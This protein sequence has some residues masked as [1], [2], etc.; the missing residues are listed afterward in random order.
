M[1]K[2][3]K[4]RPKNKH[5]TKVLTYPKKSVA[6]VGGRNFL[7]AGYGKTGETYL[8][9]TN[10]SLSMVILCKICLNFS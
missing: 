10:K 5:L 8:I 2:S 6:G 7:D 9:Y 1:I 3:K 4:K